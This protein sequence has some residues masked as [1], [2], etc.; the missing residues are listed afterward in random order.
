MY[1]F[2]QNIQFPNSSGL[3]RMDRI[4][5]P[6]LQFFFGRVGLELGRGVGE[7]FVQALSDP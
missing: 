5:F 2:I 6:F 3:I 4:L 1:F 7:R